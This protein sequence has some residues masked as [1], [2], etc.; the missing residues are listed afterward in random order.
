[1]TAHIVFMAIDPVAPATTSPAMIRVIRTEIGFDGL[2]MSDDIAMEA[3]TGTVGVR[4]GAAI[5]AGC[6]LVLH[7]NG[8][9]AEMREVAAAVPVLVGDAERRADAA[10]AARR[11]AEPI[12][13]EAARAAFAKLLDI[14]RMA[15]G[16]VPQ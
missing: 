1:M 6:D 4:A 13:L 15:A 12:D 14:S 16:T 9:P 5:A 8:E 7:C 2:L 11:L 3:L 10:L